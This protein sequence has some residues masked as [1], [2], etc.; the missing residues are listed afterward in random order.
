MTEQ[1]LIYF[2]STPRFHVYLAK[3]NN[4]FD[5]AYELYKVNIELSVAFYPL[6]SVL[7]ISLRNA[8]NENLKL[9]FKD[10]CWFKNHLPVDFLPFVSDAIKKL[11]V[12]NKSI[13]A[14]RIIAELNF[15]FWNKLFNRHYTALLWKPLRLIFRNTPKHLRQRDTIA[16]A[17]YRIRSLRNRIYQYEPVVGNLND[18]ESKYNEMLTFLTWLDNDLPKLIS[19]IDRFN[20][21]LKKAK[22]I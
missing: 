5:K 2:I 1:Q 16:D 12:Q 9:H 15:G 20:D 4:D 22:A 8:I 21:N 10:D 7:E 3:T 18:L 11:T 17:L 19:D 13:T 6:L 14:D